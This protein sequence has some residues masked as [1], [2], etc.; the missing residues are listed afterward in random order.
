MVWIPCRAIST[1]S[2]SRSSLIAILTKIYYKPDLSD[3]SVFILSMIFV[4]Q[5]VLLKH[6]PNEPV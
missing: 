6:H 2:A 1:A 3:L 5:A 4:A